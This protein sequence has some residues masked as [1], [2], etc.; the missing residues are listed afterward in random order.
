MFTAKTTEG[1]LMYRSGKIETAV[2]GPGKDRAVEAF[3]CGG[4]LSIGIDVGSTS[5]DVVVV[6]DKGRIII[7]D[8]RRTKA[9]PVQTVQSQLLDFDW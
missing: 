8:Y 5:S 9:R 6:D 4:G 1:K 7:S 3:R 2:S